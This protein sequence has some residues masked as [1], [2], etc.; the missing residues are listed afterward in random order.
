MSFEKHKTNYK[1]SATSKV[2]ENLGLQF[3]KKKNKASVYVILVAF[4]VKRQIW[5]FRVKMSFL[6][7]FCG[8]L[9]KKH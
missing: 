6:S 4:I 9:V 8:F 2:S 7:A 1:K 3:H 5:G